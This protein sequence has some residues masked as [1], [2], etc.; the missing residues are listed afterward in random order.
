M[1]VRIQKMQAQRAWKART[2]QT[3]PTLS[4]M[5][6]AGVKKARSDVALA[7]DTRVRTV[8][9]TLLKCAQT[10]GLSG[11]KPPKTTS[12]LA[13]FKGVPTAQLNDE[14]ALAYQLQ[15]FYDLQSK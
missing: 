13:A 5:I 14:I 7:G 11:V 12:V 6:G 4:S 1:D 3:L 10:F 9:N 8:F 2:G 15:R